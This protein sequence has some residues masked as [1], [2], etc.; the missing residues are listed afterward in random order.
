MSEAEGKREIRLSMAL[1]PVLFLIGALAL[2][3]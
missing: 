1:I 3:R 2:R